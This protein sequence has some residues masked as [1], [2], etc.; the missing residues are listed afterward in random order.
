METAAVIEKLLYMRHIAGMFYY[1]RT[2]NYDCSLF[3][4]LSPLN[5]I[6]ALNFGV[7]LLADCC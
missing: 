3:W 7:F 6:D 4:R 2:I 1:C 5:Y